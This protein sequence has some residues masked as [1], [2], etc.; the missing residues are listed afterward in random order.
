MLR[1]IDD[2]G[3]AVVDAF[4]AHSKGEP[5]EQVWGGPFVMIDKNSDADALV[6]EATRYST[7][8]MGR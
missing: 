1:S 6:K 7:P 4:I 5:V 3:V 2:S 8:L